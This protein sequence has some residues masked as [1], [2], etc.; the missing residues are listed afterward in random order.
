MLDTLF[1]H[2]GQIFGALLIGLLPNDLALA[3][4]LPAAS[5]VQSNLRKAIRAMMTLLP[6]CRSS[7]CKL[8]Y[9]LQLWHKAE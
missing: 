8:P 2:V 1:R 6:I 5:L 7:R 9:H 4:R 3:C